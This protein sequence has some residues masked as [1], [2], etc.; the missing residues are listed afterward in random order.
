MKR[1]KCQATKREQ[2]GGGRVSRLGRVKEEGVWV[3]NEG[4]GPKE[5]I[6]IIYWRHLERST[7]VFRSF[8]AHKG[9]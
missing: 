4:K 2:E 6:Y 9:D 1:R 8:S 7:V 5:N 3:A